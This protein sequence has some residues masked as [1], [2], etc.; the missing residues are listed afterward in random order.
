MSVTLPVSCRNNLLF[1]PFGDRA[2][3]HCWFALRQ[4]SQGLDE[5]EAIALLEMK[6][7]RVAAL[8]FFIEE[9]F[10]GL[11]RIFVKPV[12][13]AAFLKARKVNLSF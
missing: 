2:D 4:F 5:F 6:I 3:M 10:S 12:V 11:E 7:Y 9:E 1:G 13:E 8:P